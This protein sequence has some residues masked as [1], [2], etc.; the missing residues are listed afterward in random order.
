MTSKLCFGEV[1]KGGEQRGWGGVGLC[2]VP[3]QDLG[4]MMRT[5]GVTKSTYCVARQCISL[6][7]KIDF[8]FFLAG[9]GGGGGVLTLIKNVF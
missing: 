1:N 5:M 6:Q 4:I 3:I 9:R 2:S 7:N 8:S